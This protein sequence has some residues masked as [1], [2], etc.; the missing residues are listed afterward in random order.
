MLNNISNLVYTSLAVF[1]SSI[2]KQFIP[3]QSFLF[4]A[5]KSKQ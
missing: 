4:V 3:N 2:K 1:Y 5:K